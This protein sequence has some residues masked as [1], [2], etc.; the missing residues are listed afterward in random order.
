M[1]LGLAGRAH[2][3]KD[4]A[5]AFLIEGPS[6]DGIAWRRVAFADPLKEASKIIFR[7]T[8]EQ[9]NGK[10]KETI[11]ERWGFTPRA[12]LQLL[13][14]E[15]CRHIRED[16]WVKSAELRV[17]G[18]VAAG[19]H[20]VLTDVRFLNEA[21]AVRS[22]GGIVV[23]VQR[24]PST[25]PFPVDPTHQSEVELNKIV[26]DAVIANEGTLDHL[27]DSIWFVAKL[28]GLPGKE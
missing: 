18:L 20:V 11:D 17:K 6:P 8:D 3:G 26:P 2:S 28:H 1:I 22:W 12:A 4:S 19:R 24:D 15:V 10:L 16:V 13:G 7:F 21:D 27:R 14:T 5:G 25:C 23:R 9:V